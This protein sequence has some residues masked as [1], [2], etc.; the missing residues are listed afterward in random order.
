MSEKDG[1]RKGS[2]IP[3]SF[4]HWAYY[5]RGDL[6]RRQAMGEDIPSHEIFLGFTRHN[7]A[8]VS[9]GPEG[10]N[11]SIKG[12]G[13]IPKPEYLQETLD[14]YMEHIRRGWRDD[15]FKEGL[16]LLMRL[17]YGKDCKERIDF[18]RFGS[19]ELALGHTWGNL[20]TNPVVTLLFY[21]PPEISYEIRGK[22]EI[23]EEGSVYHRLINAQHD[24]YHQ[25][26]VESWNNRPAYIFIIEEIYDNSA[27][28]EGFGS[29]IY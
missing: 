6:I 29:P 22:A 9:Y 8:V 17:I 4:I 15:Y 27:T 14:A 26:H 25:P 11:A 16:K 18:T 13:Y 24:V 1:V 12:V 3:E 28:E 20:Q 5:D 23:H 19:L 7:P 2:M 21:Q 10:L